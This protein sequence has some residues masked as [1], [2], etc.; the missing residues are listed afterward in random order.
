MTTTKAP[1]GSP[2]RRR[3]R[4]VSRRRSSRWKR[5]ASAWRSPRAPT[6]LARSPRSQSRRRVSHDQRISDA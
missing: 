6:P 5:M 2:P 1:D 4:G 3:M